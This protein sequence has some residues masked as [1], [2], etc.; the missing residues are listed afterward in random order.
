MN[1]FSTHLTF[2]SAVLE[3]KM[4]SW[5]LS[6]REISVSWDRLFGLIFL[7]VLLPCARVPELPATALTCSL[8]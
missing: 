3:S 1:F 6:C 2:G 8:V 5:Q 4:P 7:A